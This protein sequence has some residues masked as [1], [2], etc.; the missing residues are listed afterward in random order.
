MSESSIYTERAG[1]VGTIYINAPRRRNA[2]SVSMWEA[3]PAA[4]DEL[5][6]DRAVRVLVIRGAGTDAFSAGADITE[7]AEQRSTPERARA[8]AEKTHRA[9]EHLTNCVKPT[10]ALIH[11]YCIGGG[12]ELALCTD[13][14]VASESAQFGITPARLGISLGWSDLRNLLWLAGPANAKEILLTAGRFSAARIKEMGLVNRIVPAERVDAEVAAIAAEM[15][16][17]SPA[18]VRWLKEAIEIIMRDPAVASVADPEG[19]A[20]ELF[21]GP[22]YQEGVR[23]FLEKR[24]PAF[25]PR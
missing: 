17:V 3:I 18:S 9:F 7:F 11:G 2:L 8:Y 20:T 19:R 1:D 23:A 24:A 22:D 16:A 4:I 15:A 5:A 10:I 14:R 21:G 6:S 13:V 12:F 25:A